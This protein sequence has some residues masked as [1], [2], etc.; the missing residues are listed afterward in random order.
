MF[1]TA[2]KC[3]INPGLLAVCH[4]LRLKLCHLKNLNTHRFKARFC[5]DFR[6]VGI[7]TFWCS[8]NR[9]YD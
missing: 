1:C 8:S 2:H 3:S 5:K 9:A 7:A 4:I 6:T